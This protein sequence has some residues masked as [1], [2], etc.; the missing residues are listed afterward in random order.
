[1]GTRPNVII[2]EDDGADPT[3]IKRSMPEVAFDSDATVLQR[4]R[5]SR[6]WLEAM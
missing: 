4:I 2:V 5:K 3:M 6:R 1:M